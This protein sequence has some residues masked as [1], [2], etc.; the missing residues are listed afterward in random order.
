MINDNL[1]III[2]ITIMII[3]II[4]IMISKLN[5]KNFFFITSTRD[6]SGLTVFPSLKLTH[7]LP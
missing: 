6:F 7:N 2:I 1:V 4:I 5:L 3:I